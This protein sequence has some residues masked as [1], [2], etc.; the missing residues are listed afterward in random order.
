VSSY[1][2]QN[3]FVTTCIKQAAGKDSLFGGS[4]AGAARTFLSD[5]DTNLSE[6]ELSRLSELVAEAQAAESQKL[7]WK[8][9]TASKV[10]LYLAT[11]YGPWQTLVTNRRDI[12]FQT[13]Q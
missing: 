5:D 12:R 2:Y 1:Q 9:G 8:P 4:I 7:D 10:D 11:G 13:A 6:Q 3:Q